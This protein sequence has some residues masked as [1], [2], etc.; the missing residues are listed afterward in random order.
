MILRA[1]FTV[2]AGFLPVWAAKTCCKFIDDKQAVYGCSGLFK[3]L[4]V[5]IFR[6]LE[7]FK[8]CLKWYF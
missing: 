1:I 8:G 7:L 6:C 4:F 5:L 3:Q 2:F